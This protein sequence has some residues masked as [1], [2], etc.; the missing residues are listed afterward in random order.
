MPDTRHDVTPHA[1]GSQQARVW[2]LGHD[3][4]RMPGIPLFSVDIVPFYWQREKPFFEVIC[5]FDQ[6]AGIAVDTPRVRS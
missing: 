2:R 4:S 6:R 5:K 1:V 3:L